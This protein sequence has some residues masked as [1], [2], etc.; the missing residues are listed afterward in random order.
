MLHLQSVL[1][2][3]LSVI[4]NSLAR[5]PLIDSP[6]GFIDARMHEKCARRK[7]DC[8]LQALPINP[9]K[10]F[11]MI[12]QYFKK[13]RTFS[14]ATGWKL[15][16]P[17]RISFAGSVLLCLAL[18]PVARGSQNLVLGWN[19]DADPGTV[20][21][22]LYYGSVS[23]SYS[24]RVD[25]GTNTTATVSS[26]KEGQTNFFVITGYNIAGIEGPRS[27]E[28]VYNVPGVLLTA[29]K[30][31]PA[32]PMNLK[33]SVAP[34]HWYEIQASID[35]KTWATISQTSTAVSNAV[36]TYQDSQITPSSRRF[37]RLILH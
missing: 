7:Q 33:F 15:I 26:L 35:L 9:R 12:I 22:V 18:C 3:R 6:D 32:S 30:S 34:G 11:P 37:Y 25:V 5:I 31:T 24:N 27:A 28:I 29:P 19:P 14:Q 17:R 8:G 4:R 21:Y 2:Q 23:G 20:G 13:L 36:V 1:N 16:S 10:A